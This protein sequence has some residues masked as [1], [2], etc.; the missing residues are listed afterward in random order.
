MNAHSIRL[1]PS[2][3]PTMTTRSSTLFL[4][5]REDPGRRARPQDRAQSCA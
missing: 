4:R 3:K 1:M 2:R 5:T